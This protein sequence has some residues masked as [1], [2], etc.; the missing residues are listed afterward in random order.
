MFLNKNSSRKMFTD[1]VTP[2]KFA[3]L[4]ATALTHD[5]N[6]HPNC[7]QIRVDANMRCHNINKSTQS[8]TIKNFSLWSYSPNRADS[9]FL[10]YLYHTIRHTHPVGLLRT[11]DQIFAEA[12]TYTTHQQQHKR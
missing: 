12:A 7:S 8:I 6:I 11:R 3:F 5:A 1:Y 4:L 9:L 10:R 2:D